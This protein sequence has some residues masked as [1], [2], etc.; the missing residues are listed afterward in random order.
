MPP[1]FFPLGE[2]P[3]TVTAEDVCGQR[4]TCTAT[5]AVVDTT[6][7]AIVCPADVTLECNA[8]GG[9]DAVDPRVAAFLAGASAT[10][11]CDADTP[12]AN[13]APA[14]FGLGATAVTFRARDDSGNPGSCVAILTVADTTRPDLA[15]SV[16]PHSLWPPNHR[17]VTVDAAVA[18]SDACDPAPTFRLSRAIS[19]EPESG[20]GD[21]DTSEDVAGADL[22]SP[23]T[24]VEL[25]AERST[26]GGDRVYTLTYTAS[27]AAG[28]HV[29]A[30]AEVSVRRDLARSPRAPSALRWALPT[31]GR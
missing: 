4:S 2:T 7:P 29:D 1:T 12:I 27:D 13:D 28:N 30:S 11:V 20:R 18:V 5:V 22:G 17:Y 25:R 26:R 23:D 9:V 19:N 10:D 24:S 8:P 16:S 15:V 3:V 6:P 14:F 21:A 31:G